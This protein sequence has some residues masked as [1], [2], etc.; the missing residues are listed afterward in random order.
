MDTKAPCLSGQYS[1]CLLQTRITGQQDTDRGVQ[2]KDGKPQR[3]H[4]ESLKPPQ[5]HRQN[6]A[7]HTQALPTSK[8]R[9]SVNNGRGVKVAL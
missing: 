6:D 4:I 7:N 8:G 5:Y 3:H 2:A 1:D 9:W